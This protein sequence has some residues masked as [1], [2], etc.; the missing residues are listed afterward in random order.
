MAFKTMTLQP[1]DSK[2]YLIEN[3]H[4]N[5]LSVLGSGTMGCGITLCL[6]QADLP[7]IL[8]SRK[9]EGKVKGRIIRAL[10]EEFY[11]SALSRGEINR[12]LS[13]IYITSELN[14]VAESDIVIESV[15]ED[16]EV[17]RE[18]FQRLSHICMPSTILASNTSTFCIHEIASQVLYPERVIG[19]HFFNP[20]YQTAVI[21]VVCGQATSEETFSLIK[22]LAM[23]LGK[24][25]IR[26]EDKPGFIVS[27]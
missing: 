16:L 17:K 5:Q 11:E 25:V 10:E 19:M 8:W 24:E 22:K 1:V 2:H 13:N 6:A 23:V 21:E 20:A 18:L 3:V 15:V 26:V 12:F 4:I 7:V 14:L 27:Q 9:G